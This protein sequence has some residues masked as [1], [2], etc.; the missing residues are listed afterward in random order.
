M[1][2]IFGS[3]EAKTEGEARREVELGFTAYVHNF[4]FVIGLVGKCSI[5]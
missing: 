3:G 2:R 4:E 5:R 1:D